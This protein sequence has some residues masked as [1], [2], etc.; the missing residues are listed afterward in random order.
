LCEPA[1]LR[2]LFDKHIRGH[3]EANAA[4]IERGKTSGELASDADPEL[5]IDAVFG[6]IFY[7]LLFRS[8]PLTEEFSD[9]L[10][11]QVFRGAQ[12]LLHVPNLAGS[13]RRDLQSDN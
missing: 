1:I 3:Q 8:S 2:E 10:V 6:A 13:N 9:K 7:R 4:D 12:K 5:I 11:R